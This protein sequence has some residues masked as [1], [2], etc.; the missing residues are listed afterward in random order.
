MTET[1]TTTD[2]ST[3]IR[4]QSFRQPWPVAAYGRLKS[5]PE[6][7]FV[8]EI[9]GFEPGGS[10]EHLCLLVEKRGRNTQDVAKDIAGYAKQPLRNVGFSG[11]KDK[12]AISR[13][14]F[15]IPATPSA[16][17]DWA[18]LASRG[19]TV[20]CT[21]RHGR[22]LRRGSHRE[23]RF[24]LRIADVRGGRSAII[25]NIEQVQRRGFA[26][27]FGEQ[28]FGRER[29]NVIRGIDMLRGNVTIR[30]RFLRKLLLSAVRSWLFNVHLDLRIGQ[31]RWLEVAAGRYYQLDGS[32]SFF[33]SRDV[34]DLPPRLALAD[35]HPTGPLW[36][37]LKK[38]NIPPVVNEERAEL[39]FYDDL[40]PLLE[41]K[42]LE[43]Q[44][45]ALR[46]VPRQ[47]QWTL[48]K[49]CLSLAFILPRGAYATSFVA[50]LLHS[51]Q[52]RSDS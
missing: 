49:N 17:L 4:Q 26:N 31:D 36:G 21:K 35:I 51:E 10:G 34:S 2:L 11:L 8:E 48:D 15:S 14:W 32:Q 23:N 18:A 45:R 30:D 13:Q 27:Y 20:L 40:L 29:L 3:T 37:R 22:K 47:L 1:I 12:T 9:L 6:D 38:G 33:L 50:A 42:G 43:F 16:A 5:R 39:S 25:E 52:A 19:V 44:R 41:D 28:R 7:F 24:Q 46:I